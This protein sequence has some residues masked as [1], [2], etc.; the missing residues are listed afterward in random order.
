MKKNLFVFAVAGAVI[1][2]IVVFYFGVISYYSQ[3]SGQA[4]QLKVYKE[5]IEKIMAKKGE[6]PSQK[7]VEAYEAR[8]KELDSEI[9]GCRN[10]Y[11]E[12]DKTLEK[13][14]PGLKIDKNEM[15]AVGDFKATYLSEKDV[16]IRQLK[17]KK[18]YGASEEE[19]GEENKAEE[20]K[21]LG[22][23]E[24][25]A[26]NLKKLQKQFWIQKALF[27]SIMESNV[28]K[29]E[30]LEFPD[31]NQSKAASF[32]YGV[33]IPFNLTVAIQNKDIPGFVH[34]TMKFRNDKDASS[35]CVLFKN[36]SIARIPDEI[37]NIPENIEAKPVP[38]KNRD[39]YKPEQVRL[40]LSKLVIEGEA[41]DF[42]FALAMQA[43]KEDQAVKDKAAKDK[44][45]KNKAAKGKPGK[46]S[47]DT[48]KEENK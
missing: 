38:D 37:K 7:W 32:T 16:T 44:A 35:I 45:A 21:D 47:K 24:P 10:Y 31:I 41:L 29:C 1:A 27:N 3:I 9:A 6:V 14:F 36:I 40:P 26:D 15:P 13:W 18:L 12:I 34:N 19:S 28:V 5:D 30:K 39:T 42:D 4:D 8:Q 23:G 33:L 17:A 43:A 46:D 22:F 48:D 2:A 11:I 20:G 25:T